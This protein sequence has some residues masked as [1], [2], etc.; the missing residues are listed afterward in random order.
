MAARNETAVR[1]D[2]LAKLRRDLRDL[3][4][5]ALKELR[6]VLKSAADEVAREASATAPRRTG[7]LARSYQPFTRG[8][9]AGVRSKLPYAGVV[10]WGGTI[11][12]RGVPIEFQRRQPIGRALERRQDQII[13]KVADGIDDI[14]RRNGWH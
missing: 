9:V 14:A 10:E 4:K 5:D 7:N 13:E 11:R 12:P 3:D 2:G 8:N 1:I 6:L